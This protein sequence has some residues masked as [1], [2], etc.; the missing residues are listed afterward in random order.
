MMRDD[1]VMVFCALALL[2]LAAYGSGEFHRDCAARGG[3]VLVQP[4]RPNG[5]VRPRE[6][7]R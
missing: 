5:C 3:Q 6:K 4:G 2:A 1:V 7:A